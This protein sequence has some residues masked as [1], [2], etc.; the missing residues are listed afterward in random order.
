[1]HTEPQK[2]IK[3]TTKCKNR[4][5]RQHSHREGEYLLNYTSGQHRKEE[6]VQSR[7]QPRK[8]EKKEITQKYWS[9]DE[10]EGKSKKWEEKKKKKRR[11][12][13]DTAT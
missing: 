13:S 1:M 5:I 4:G 2:R 12:W 9:K 8:E 6:G 3:R 7:Q 11:K 10:Q